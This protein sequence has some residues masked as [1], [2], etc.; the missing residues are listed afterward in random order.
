[1]FPAFTL[2]FQRGF[3]GGEKGGLTMLYILRET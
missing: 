3:V 2:K 1:M